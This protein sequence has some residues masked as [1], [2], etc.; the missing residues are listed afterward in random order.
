MRK[1]IFLFS[2]SLFVILFS[3]AV[4]ANTNGFDN[5]S[6]SSDFSTN[7][8]AYQPTFDQ[9]YS[10]RDISNYWP[11]LAKMDSNQCNATSD[12]LI[13]IPPGGCSPGVV[14]SDLLAEQSVPVF[15][16]LYAIKIN[17]L[18]QVSSIKSISFKGDYPKG[19]RSVAFY[20]ARA[21]VNSYTT[22]V[23]DPLI[24]N[25]GYVVIIL[26]QNKVEANLTDWVSGNLTATISYDADKAYGTGKGEYYLPEM[27]DSEWDANYEGSSFWNGR[28]FLRATA[29]D[30]GGARIEV[31]GSKE[32]VLRTFNLKVGETSSL[33]YMPG[34][35]C[36]AGLKVKLNDIVAPEDAALLNVD[37]ENIWVRQGTS[38]LNGKCRVSRL[39]VKANNEG[40]VDITCSGTGGVRNLILKNATGAGNEDAPIADGTTKDY[41]LKSRNV[42]DDLVSQYGAELKST[43]EAYGEEAILQQIVLAKKLGQM[44]TAS[45]LMG[46]FVDKYPSSK[47]IDYIRN[48]RKKLGN[49]NFSQSYTS[50]YAG[51]KFYSISVEDFKVDDEGESEV[52]LKVGNDA[53]NN[54]KEGSPGMNVSDGTIKIQKILPG[55]VTIQFTSIKRE[56]ASKSFTI[57]EGQTQNIGG[58]DVYVSDVRVKKVA[59]V[60]LIPEVKNSKTEAN[61]S[62]NIGIEK[63]N[64]QLSPEKTAEMIKNLNASIKKWDNIVTH[65]GDV[66]TGLKGACFATSAILMVKNM[67]SGIGGEALAREKV[68]KEYKAICDR[69]HPEMTHT[70]CYND[71]KIGAEIEDKVKAMTASLKATNDAMES[72]QTWNTV[73]SG[74]LFGGKAVNDVGYTKSL[75]E[76]IGADTVSVDVDGKTIPIPV[77]NIKSTSQLQAVLLW[78]NSG[79][80]VKDITKA[81]M[82]SALR[83]LALEA[84][85][86][87]A[88]ANIAKEFVFEINGEKVEFPVDVLR[89]G[90]SAFSDKGVRVSRKELEKIVSPTNSLGLGQSVKSEDKIGVQIIHAGSSNYLYL[91]DGNHMQL[92]IYKVNKTGSLLNIGEK[93]DKIPENKGQSVS[94]VSTGSC[95]N[96]WPKGKAKVSYYESGKNNGLPAIVPFDLDNGWYAMVPNSGGTFIDSSPQGYTASGDVSY[97]KICNIG[98]NQLMENCGGDDLVQTFSADSVASVKNIGGCSTDVTE[99]YNKAREAIRQ[100]SQKHDSCVGS[101]GE[102]SIRILDNDIDCGAPFSNVGGFECQDFM[103]PQDCT[104][105]F[106]VC[107]PVICP[108]SRCDLGGKMPV[109]D[110]IQTGII[111][112]L[113]L[114]L[115]NAKEGIMFPICLSGVHA[116][117]DSYNSI[118]KSERD[119]LQH[120]LDT[121]EMVGVCDEITSIY[122]CEFFWREAAP[123]LDHLLPSFIESAFGSGSGV[124]GGGE[125]AFTQ[126]AWNKMKQSVSLFKDN[127]AQNAFKAFNIRSTAEVGGKVC[128]GFIGTRFPSS[129]D[130]LDNL[131]KPESPSQFYAQFSSTLF[132]EATVPSTSQYKV[133]F[134]I[135]AGKD[136]GAQYRVYLK[137]PPATSY[138]SNRATVQVKSGYVSAGDSADETVDFTAPTGYKDLCVVINAK[139]ECGFKSVSTDL[140]IDILSQKYIKEQASDNT[141]TTEKDCISGTSSLLPMANLNLQAGAEEAV[142]PNIALRGIVRVCATQNPSTGVSS[143]D[144]VSCSGDGKGC[145]TGYTCNSDGYCSGKDS[146]GNDVFQQSNSDWQDVGYCGDPK[147][148]CWLQVSSVK[149]DLTKLQAVTGEPINV[150]DKSKGL[151]NGGGLTLKEVR[152]IL[153]NAR[154][155]IKTLANTNGA[156]SGESV[157]NITDELDKVIGTDKVVGAGTNANRAE[158]LALKASVYRVVVEKGLE[159]GVAEVESGSLVA[160]NAN[161]KSE[162]SNSGASVEI[163]NKNSE[164]KKKG[165]GIVKVLVEEGADKLKNSNKGNKFPILEVECS[166]EGYPAMTAAVVAPI[167]GDVAYPQSDFESGQT[168]SAEKASPFY[169]EAASRKGQFIIKTDKNYFK[170]NA[171]FVAKITSGEFLTGNDQKL[172]NIEIDFDNKKVVSF[173]NDPAYTNKLLSV[174]GITK[175]DFLADLEDSIFSG[176][177]GLA[178]NGVEGVTEEQLTKVLEKLNKKIINNRSCYCG[179]RCEEYA[180]DILNASNT[181]KVDPFLITSIMMQ[182]NNCKK[183]VC[184]DDVSQVSCGVMQVNKNYFEEGQNPN[185]LADN[186]FV[187]TKYLRNRYDALKSLDLGCYSHPE[188]DWE[189]AVHGY[190]GWS[191][192]NLNYPKDVMSIYNTVRNDVA[193]A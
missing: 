73:N 166:K 159:K 146:N 75:Q 142:N 171:G 144:K 55:K 3:S 155:N 133:Y 148:R 15:C 2:V 165:R 9:L 22:L 42:T 44:A 20:P 150:L 180:K 138:Y 6:P 115:P 164:E 63:R 94:I 54:K 131:L 70:E 98:H 127:Y 130:T 49:T 163:G 191:C 32:N 102:R 81:E 48:E 160:D 64:I 145:A 36:D 126:Q 90:R 156:V 33:T 5:P 104:L 190:N 185:S 124:R 83:N 1:N 37:G 178:G 60:S 168:C 12:F 14:R 151:I 139:E 99:L 176:E 107:D 122:K 152:D 109:S 77:G 84:K 116:G 193:V 108:P 188:G 186:I 43:G 88:Q 25:I 31:L 140:G 123:F 39:N 61:F 38:F 57:L 105:M 69:E 19:V 172:T 7:Y 62:F 169:M 11:I 128:K 68:M 175:G 112:S 21:A 41:F 86:N 167:T 4:F 96:P 149:G 125:Y 53:K 136:Q 27:S 184:R 170:Q 50:V 30:N 28:G 158:A 59:Y 10:S 85:E 161:K 121:G 119:C 141:I 113:T 179:D 110:V 79:S 111:G 177:G 66:I 91:F 52:D 183:I 76:K 80:D 8:Q 34:Y 106:N 89:E 117:L 92:G 120:S 100:A 134:H 181:F 147:L 118:L 87:V 143:G 162:N 153:I 135:Y 129:A 58:T 29:V 46:T 47:S 132:S 40:Q 67:A 154:T 95:S 189:K 173:G 13:G 192:S 71:D 101:G 26:K 137:N 174:F 51:D 45:K 16:Q 18:I 56:V 65:L 17:P 182:E 93:L 74:G 103:S 157:K 78:K 114:C 35:Y 24:N 72:A 23:G 97:F 82:D 187:G